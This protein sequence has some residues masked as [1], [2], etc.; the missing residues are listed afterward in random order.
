MGALAFYAQWCAIDRLKRSR[1]WE[2]SRF[3]LSAG[4]EFPEKINRQKASP[5]PY[6][7]RFKTAILELLTTSG[8]F[9]IF[10]RSKSDRKRGSSCFKRSKL[11]E[12]LAL[13]VQQ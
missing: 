3:S 8:P 5:K 1:V 4:P 11:W 13:T 6:Q 7:K 12:R 2:L 9:C 10:P